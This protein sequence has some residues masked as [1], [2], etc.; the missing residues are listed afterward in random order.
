VKEAS[1]HLDEEAFQVKNV[2]LV[3]SFVWLHCLQTVLWQSTA[4]LAT[5]KHGQHIIERYS[6]TS[7]LDGAA[8]PL[9]KKIVR[10]NLDT[11]ERRQFFFP[12]TLNFLYSSINEEYRYVSISKLFNLVVVLLHCSMKVAV[13]RP[14]HV[15]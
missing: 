5:H 6:S 9:L 15:F 8:L 1:V 10:S 11:D 13:S 14:K 12:C 3:F 2:R 4:G 7:A